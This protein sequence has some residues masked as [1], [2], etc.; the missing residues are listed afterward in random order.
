ML[1][2]NCLP[3]FTILLSAAYGQI[4][5][6]GDPHNHASQST[7]SIPPEQLEQ[8]LTTVASDP[9]VLDD[10]ILGRP[11]VIIDEQSATLELHLEPVPFRYLLSNS[12]PLNV[13]LEAMI[14]VRVLRRDLAHSFPDTASWD[15]ELAAID[16]A[17]TDCLKAVL[18]V[19]SEQQ[20]PCAAV[21]L[22]FDRLA[23]RV[24]QQATLRK[25]DFAKT[26]GDSIAPFPVRLVF[27]PEAARLRVMST[28]QYKICTKLHLSQEDHYLDVLQNPAF[29]IGRYHYRVE[30][31]AKLGGP[32]EGNFEVDAQTTTLNI[33]AVG[34]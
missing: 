19:S 4:C 31:P 32:Q 1:K 21:P 7:A 30:W 11:R 2:R 6:A 12:D 16:Q 17:N 23:T 27:K 33:V 9:L 29:L 20:P 5:L 28:L 8:F 3:L 24:Q 15:P 25:L 13:P 22:A 34:R 10:P 18:H 26:R 14:R